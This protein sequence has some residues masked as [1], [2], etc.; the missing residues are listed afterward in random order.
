LSRQIDILSD[1]ELVAKLQAADTK[2][3]EVIYKKYAPELYQVAYNLLRNREV[4]EDLIHDLFVDI[5]L[6]KSSHN[7]KVLK[8]YLYSATKSR[9]LMHL[10]ST[11]VILDISKIELAD[12]GLCPDKMLTKKEITEVSGR[13]ISRLPKKCREI[14]QLSRLEQRSHKEIALLKGISIKTVENQITIA[15]QRLRP[16]LKDYMAFVLMLSFLFK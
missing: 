4:C 6:R 12:Y 15:L 7:I 1:P 5:W 10:R 11:K 3:F 9:V 16:V 8:L 13:E 14:Y 2:A